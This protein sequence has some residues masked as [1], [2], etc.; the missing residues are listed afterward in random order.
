VELNILLLTFCFTLAGVCLGCIS[1]LVPGIHV[2]T[3]CVILI[4]I[5]P[6]VT[7][8]MITLTNNIDPTM[9]SIL[10]SSMIVSAATVHSFLDFIPSVFLGAPED[11]KI[12]SVL[13]G[14]RLLLRGKGMEAVECAAKGS[15]IGALLAITLAFPFRL[16]MG[17]PLKLY[18]LLVPFIPA[19][20]IAIVALLIVSEKED[21]QI[22]AIIDAREG[23]VDFSSPSVILSP[24]F[25]SEG[26][27][28][29]LSGRIRRVFLRSYRISTPNGCWKLRI[30]GNIPEGY[31]TI[32]GVWRLQRRRIRKKLIALAI[33]LCSGIL[34]FI[35]L[36]GKLP[37]NPLLPG[38]SDNL[39]FPLLSGLFGVPS[40]LLSFGRSKIPPQESKSPARINC[41]S[42][43]KGTIIGAFVGW[44]PGVTSTT[45]AVI[46]SFVTSKRKVDPIDSS[47][48]FI[49]MVSALGTS[50]TVFNLIAL[51]TIGK[52]R[53]GAMI[54]VKEIIGSQEIVASL[55]E[56]SPV[57]SLMLFSI[58][59]ASLIGFTL[60]ILFGKRISKRLENVDMKRVNTV[61]LLFLI[62]LVLLM[63]GPVGFVVLIAATSLGLLPPLL[64]VKRVQLTGCLL[65]P[66]IIFFVEL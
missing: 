42:A 20:L 18:E 13:P 37:L 19:I 63:T 2:N 22:T 53:S 52:S 43:I 34:G 57:F 29:R 24:P 66:I 40:L 14:H 9:I 10:F 54:A 31:A 8:H 50:A 62:S 3:L 35:V 64:G 27:R 1:G 21:N 65:L 51:T 11:S 61:V 6:S 7:P 26:A 4:T 46:A 38:I 33:F 25:P 36:R 17:D 44:C 55:N 15:L 45:G 59:F 23:S 48:D 32:E 28:V 12:L 58:F 16:L 56:I 39:L 30:K 5:Y 41:C 60:T 49:T 47:K